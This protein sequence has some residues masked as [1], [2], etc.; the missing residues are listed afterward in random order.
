[1]ASL[2]S[3]LNFGDPKAA[4]RNSPGIFIYKAGIGAI[5]TCKILEADRYGTMAD[6]LK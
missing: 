5:G 2:L 3:C 6:E 4:V 1:M